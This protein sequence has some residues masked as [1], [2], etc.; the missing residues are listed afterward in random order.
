[1]E[2]KIYTDGA[3]RNNPGPAGWAA[4]VLEDGVIAK[5]LGGRSS[6]A[7][8]NQMELSAVIEGLK[9]AFEK[10]SKEEIHVFTDSA[11]TMNGIMTWIHG[12][13]KNG[14]RTAAKKPVLN[15]ELWQALD[16][17]HKK[18]KVEWH[19]VKGHSGDEFNERADVIATMFA[20]NEFIELM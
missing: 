10:Y 4:V 9:Y 12:W 20:D 13:K 1:M 5:E 3:A 11:Y 16:D 18:L 19:K 8:N 17:V 6:S 14:W 7:T 15:K 2:I